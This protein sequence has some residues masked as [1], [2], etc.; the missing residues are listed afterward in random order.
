MRIIRDRA[1]LLQFSAAVQQQGESIALV[2]TM[3]NLHEGHLSLVRGA[4]Q[5]VDCVIVSVFV[6]PTQFGPHE[7]FHKYP[8]TEAR[9]IDQ[10]QA[11]SPTAVFIPTVEDMYPAEATTYVE[12][13]ALA[14]ILEGAS[15]PGH[16]RGVA[17][18][19]MKLLN[20]SRAT[21]LWLGRK[22]Y[23][24]YRLLQTMLADL[25][26]P[27]EVIAAETVREAD[28]LALSSRN[29]Y[30]SESE[31]QRASLLHQELQHIKQQILQGSSDF[32]A[33]QK[34]AIQGLQQQG[35][36]PDYVEIRESHSL[37][38][39]T[40]DDPKVILAAARLGRT[41]LIDNIAVK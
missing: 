17:T 37:K 26:L 2:P 7:D 8:R 5:Q 35:F 40:A 11:L 6:N 41:R 9:D 16:F 39:A 36:E 10:L 33:L 28:G 19:V 22:D 32:V 29:Q 25:D 38:P 24:Q 23:Q 12:V 3:G 15:R 14:D 27:C 31:R 30:L 1:E 18:I 20:L 34:A 21:Q 4:L 13:P